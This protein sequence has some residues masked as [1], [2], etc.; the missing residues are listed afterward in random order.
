M[1]IR[2]YLN[3]EQTLP[4]NSGSAVR[5][6]ALCFDTSPLVVGVATGEGTLVLVGDG[7]LLWAFE[8]ASMWVVEAT[9]GSSAIPG[10]VSASCNRK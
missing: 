6:S 1:T 2:T 7:G 3:V 5:S 10:G 4:N 9:V 8:G